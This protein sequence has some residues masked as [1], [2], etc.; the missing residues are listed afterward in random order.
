MQVIHEPIWNE[1]FISSALESPLS[2]C[3]YHPL[4]S[5]ETHGRKQ[6]YMLLPLEL[7]F[8]QNSFH[9]LVWVGKGYIVWVSRQVLRVRANLRHLSRLSCPGHASS[10][11]SDGNS[12]FFLKLVAIHQS[13]QIIRSVRGER[14]KEKGW[15]DAPFICSVQQTFITALQHFV[16]KRGCNEHIVQYRSKT[17]FSLM[18][19]TN[20]YKD[21]ATILQKW[22]QKQ[23]R[24][25]GKQT[26]P[27]I[28][29]G[30]DCHI[31]R[32]RVRQ[33]LSNEAQRRCRVVCGRWEWDAGRGK[34]TTARR[35]ILPNPINKMK[36]RV[37]I[38]R[39]EGFLLKTS[40]KRE[41]TSEMEQQIER[42]FLVRTYLFLVL[43]SAPVLLSFSPILFWSLYSPITLS[44]TSH[45][46]PIQEAPMDAQTIH[47]CQIYI[48]SAWN[49]VGTSPHLPGWPTQPVP[50]CLQAL[51]YALYFSFNLFPCLLLCSVF[52]RVVAF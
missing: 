33:S 26:L 5:E 25:R 30:D 18:N 41:W 50:Y 8:R 35:S 9:V 14:E 15:M 27:V 28:N 7:L 16:D 39:K 52:W 31:P 38:E 37:K 47:Q 20:N 19:N 51:A 21:R 44:P 42:V 46:L 3:K 1:F 23:E 36:K 43:P 29:M 12:S 22:E 11:C 13:V 40:W 48:L 6:H 17:A 2:D 32:E 45:E 4:L 34:I 49:W 24:E 10:F